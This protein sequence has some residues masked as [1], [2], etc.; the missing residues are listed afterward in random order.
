[1]SNPVNR[2][3]NRQTQVKTQPTWQR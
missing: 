1:L 2:Q 3:T